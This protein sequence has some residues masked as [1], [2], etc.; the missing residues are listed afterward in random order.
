MAGF[1]STKKQSEILRYIFLN[2][3]KKK[4]IGNF[5]KSFRD[6]DVDVSD[7][8]ADMVIS[9]DNIKKE[10]SDSSHDEDLIDSDKTDD[11]ET[12]SSKTKNNLSKSRLIADSY[13]NRDKEMLEKFIQ[14]RNNLKSIP[15]PKTDFVTEDDDLWLIQCPSTFDVNSLCNVPILNGD[16]NKIKIPSTKYECVVIEKE[17]DQNL[18]LVLP[19]SKDLSMINNYKLKGKFVVREKLKNQC[20]ATVKEEDRTNVPFPSNLKIRHT[21]FGADFES[22]INLPSDISEKLNNPPKRSL[23]V[24]KVDNSPSKEKN[25]LNK[26]LKRKRKTSESSDEQVPKRSKKEKMWDSEISI[27]QSLFASPIKKSKKT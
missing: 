19:I 3:Y 22:H 2:S 25:V 7:S 5:K 24:K 4:N 27:E 15:L 16:K 21:L 10:K 18:T 9:T 1:P 11:E 23:K 20:E 14:E 8:D 17:S 13:D 12:F 26:N 6:E